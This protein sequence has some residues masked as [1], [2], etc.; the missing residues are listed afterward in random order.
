MTEEEA[1]HALIGAAIKVHSVLGP[2]LLESTYAACLVYELEKLGLQVRSQA[3]IPI[4]YDNL[5]IEP[6]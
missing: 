2:G 5:V 3:A 4:K 6:A 1:G